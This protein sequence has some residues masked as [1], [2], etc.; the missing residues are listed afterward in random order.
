M[1]DN[2]L[3]K[4]ESLRNEMNDMKEQVKNQEEIVKT[5]KAC[6]KELKN[7]DIALSDTNELRVDFYCN[8]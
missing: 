5:E 8:K 3:S 7:I 2:Y 6:Y 4:I 1:I